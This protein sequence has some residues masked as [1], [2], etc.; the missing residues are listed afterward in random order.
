M[1]VDKFIGD[2]KI[3]SFGWA[4]A[5]TLILSVISSTIMAILIKKSCNQRC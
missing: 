1:L 3:K 2:F 4:F 5:F